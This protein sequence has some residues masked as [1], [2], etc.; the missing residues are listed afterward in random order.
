M[1]PVQY[2]TLFKV[3]TT[4][5]EAEPD[6]F[7]FVA[8]RL[9]LLAAFPFVEGMNA[10][11]LALDHLL[12]PFTKVPV[13]KPVFIIGSPRSGSTMLFRILAKDREGFTAFKLW[14]L[15]FPSLSVQSLVRGT[16]RV[17]HLLGGPL[18]K[19]LER[20]EERGLGGADRFHRIRL[21]EPEEDEIL[22][23]HAFAS[24][25]L[26]N[27]FPVPDALQEYRHF[28]ALPE[29]RRRELMQFYVECVQRHLYF[30]G[31]DRRLL[32]KSPLFSHKVMSLHETFPDARFIL[33]VRDPAETICS[34]VSMIRTY[35]KMI[36]LEAKG[37][38]GQASDESIMRFV[39]DCYTNAL[40]GLDRLPPE[41]YH[42]IRYEHLIASPRTTVEEVYRKLEIPLND[43]FR[44]A[45]EEE[46]RKVRSYKSKHIHS[47][48]QLG[49]TYEQIEAVAAPVYERFGYPRRS[50]GERASAPR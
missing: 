1:I 40:E 6:G 37:E 22:L 29:A 16:G 47:P 24:E 18:R 10:G 14:Q 43:A 44:R 17:D 20:L 2:K 32:S 38:L 26:A 39:V 33:L 36:G 5:G 30:E 28:D 25:I 48:A 9:R 45:L 21:N 50:E 42:I 7:G 41:L 11:L 19:Q 4:R 34:L 8:R 3:I 31:G 13:E 15:L 27:A 23:M 49:L 12:F 46:D 35:R